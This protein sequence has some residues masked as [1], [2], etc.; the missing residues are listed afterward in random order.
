MSDKKDLNDFDRDAVTHRLSVAPTESSE[1]K[2]SKGLVMCESDIGKVSDELVGLTILP[3]ACPPYRMLKHAFWC[4][5]L[6]Q[7]G[8][9]SLDNPLRQLEEIL[10]GKESE[11]SCICR[12]YNL[13]ADLIIRV[14]AK[15]NDMPELTIP[16]E[17]VCF[18]ASMG[19]SI[20]FDFYLD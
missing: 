19:V 1:P 7:I 13:S 2:L 8:S 4:I 20:G 18:W 17:S 15:S 5:E 10:R 14:F 16:S 6:P 9:W 12:E 11:V 3:A